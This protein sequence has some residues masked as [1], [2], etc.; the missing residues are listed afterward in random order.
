M[1]CITATS[2]V[3]QR[4]EAPANFV[5]MRA[6]SNLGQT[7]NSKN[8]SSQFPLS[9]SVCDN[10]NRFSLHDPRFCSANLKFCG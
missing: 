2:S 9:Q 1:H 5:K 8:L 10:D 4:H 3:E 6:G 7:I